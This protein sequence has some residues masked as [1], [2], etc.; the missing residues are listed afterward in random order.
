MN[1]MSDNTHSSQ[2]EMRLEKTHPSGAQEWYCP[3]CARRFVMQLPPRFKKVVLEAG[4][5][6]AGHAGSTG[7]LRVGPVRIGRVDEPELSDTLRAALEEALDNI[8]FDGP[9]DSADQ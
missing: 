7:A 8:D 4:D 9:A 5:E 3:T 2:H 1:H 6:N